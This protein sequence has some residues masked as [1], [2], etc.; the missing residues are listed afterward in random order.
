MDQQVWS[1][2]REH[3]FYIAIAKFLFHHPEHGIVAVRD[4][5]KIQDAQKYGL[6]PLILYGLT[7][8]LL[9]IRW[10]TFS[11]LD[12]P[13]AFRDVL[14]EA[15]CEAEGLRGRPD[16]LMVNR[17]IA[18]AS[19]TLVD[20]MA[21]FGVKVEVAGAKEKSLPVSLRSAQNASMWLMGIH[22]S[23]DCSLNESIKALC[24]DALSD[25]KFHLSDSHIRGMY[26]REVGNRFHRWLSL[27]PQGPEPTPTLT[28]GLD[29]KPG[30]WLSSWESSVPPDSSRYFNRSGI[31][32][33]IW[34]VSGEKGDENTVEDEDFWED[35]IFDN[36]AEIAKNLV[37]CWP[38]PAA[39]IAKSAGITLRDLQWF[40]TGKAALDQHKRIDLEDLLSI[41][42]NES[43]GM[44]RG[45]G[46]YV[47]IARK[48]LAL[49]EAYEDISGGGDAC[50][51]EIVPRQGVADPSW[52][53]VL[54]NTY[55][56]PPTIVMIPRGEKITENLP[57]LLMNYAGIAPVPPEFYR[58]V[59]ST[60]ARACREPA[61]NIHEMI[62]FARR[63]EDR[64]ASCFWQPE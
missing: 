36:V 49:K 3:H 50:P 54:M 48:P 25:H 14:L 16:I 47:L 15:W 13:R 37:A 35:S 27:P 20:D 4:S 57:K 46:P 8:A 2:Q 51:Y 30:P 21:K 6:S 61:A 26:S 52:R 23:K 28:G 17:Y 60:C 58:D 31:D 56:E 33:R 45:V 19:P 7:V 63:Y 32:G 18:H 39:E 34:L 59:V 55:G 24:L 1:S 22:K 11:P 44:Y 12:Q 42:F 10:M 53:Y 38:N 29:W 62:E 64:W 41:E 5:I 9:P 40:I 43:R